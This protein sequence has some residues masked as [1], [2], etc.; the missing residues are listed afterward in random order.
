MEEWLEL[1]LKMKVPTTMLILSRAFRLMPYQSPEDLLKESI[2]H[3]PSQVIKEVEEPNTATVPRKPSPT[4][5]IVGSVE[6]LPETSKLSKV[7]QMSDAI[8]ESVAPADF[9]KEK[10]EALKR[11]FNH[12]QQQQQGTTT[13][14]TARLAK[15]VEA[16][17]K[18][19][20]TS[21]KQV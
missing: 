7:E 10:L 17:E 16:L 4:P 15:M 3:L 5:D 19:I 18:R 12:L 13:A 20:Q 14:T 6:D 9:Q 11:E 21:A 1:S 8:Y 2:A